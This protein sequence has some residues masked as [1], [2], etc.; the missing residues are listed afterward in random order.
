MKRIVQAIRDHIPR[1]RRRFWRYV[2][3]RRRGLG[4]IVLALLVTLVYGYW[5]LTNNERVRH[6][7]ESYLRRVTGVHVTVHDAKFR[8]FGGIVLKGVRLYVPG[9]SPDQPFLVAPRIVLRHNPAALLGGQLR[10]TDI[11]F[12]GPQV[13][14]EHDTASGVTN[15]QR[16]LDLI[17]RQQAS[18]SQQAV[19]AHLPS[20]RVRNGR[21][22]IIRRDG[23]LRHFVREAPLNLSARLEE[24][25]VYTMT[26]ES[27]LSG[28][29]GIEQ[30]RLR[31]NLAT[32]DVTGMGTVPDV[33][34]LRGVLPD[35]YRKWL[36]RYQ[37][38]GGAQVIVRSGSS[39]DQK[40]FFVELRDFS[41]RL[42]DSEG[43]LKLSNVNGLLRF[44][45]SG[46]TLV[47]R[48]VK[49]KGRIIMEG[50]TGRIPQAR[51]AKIEMWGSYDG[52]ESHS[53]FEVHVRIKDME[54]PSPGAATGELA[55]AL[56][57]FRRLYQPTGPMD[58]EVDFQRNAE[59]V[60]SYEGL[61]QAKGMSVYPKEFPYRFGNV[62]GK[63]R[64][65]KGSVETDG[66]EA[67][68]G[69]ARFVL[70]GRL[71]Y[72]LT[73]AYDVTIVSR[74]ALLDAELRNA[75]PDNFQMIWDKLSLRGST[76]ATVRLF[77]LKDDGKEDA[78]VTIEA[79]GKASMS[80]E[81]FPYRINNLF[82]EV[83]IV[84]NEVRIDSM[85]GRRGKMTCRIEGTLRDVDKPNAS[86]DLDIRAKNFALDKYLTS[87]LPR[88]TRAAVES[89]HPSGLA[90]E[91]RVKVTQKP[92]GK[93]THRI[94]AT[95][96]SGR[97][98]FE[99]FPYEVTDLSGELTILPQRVI[100]KDLRGVHRK[101]PVL[102]NGSVYLR[103]DLLGVDLSV[104]AKN[105]LLDRELFDALPRDVRSVWRTFSPSGLADV[106]LAI[107]HDAGQAG[108]KFDYG[109][110][111]DARGVDVTYRE[112]PYTFRS[113]TGR[114]IVKPG[115]IVLENLLAKQ[116]RMSTAISGEVTL[117]EFRDE[118]RLSIRASNIPIDKELLGALPPTLG[119]LTKRLRPGGE[120]DIN[121]RDLRVVHTRAAATSRP[122]TTGPVTAVTWSVRASGKQGDAGEAKPGQKQKP[123]G[124]IVLRDAVVDFG[125]GPRRVSGKLYGVA[126]GIDGAV[127]LDA[128]LSLEEVF[129]G[130]RRL[131]DIT[132]KV[133]KG[134]RS[135]VVQVKDLVGKVHGGKFAGYAQV[136]LSDPLR[137]GL[138]LSVANISL[139]ELF[140]AGITD[141][142][143]KLKVQGFLDGNIQL[144]ASV[145]DKPTRQ[146]SGVLRITKAKLYKM[147]VLLGLIQVIYLALPG[148]SA[149]T[150]GLMTY[151]LREGKLIFD[152][153]YLVGPGMSVVGSGTMD[154][155]TEK[156]K[157]S[158]LSGPPGKLPRIASIEELLGG[159][160][161]EIVEIQVTGTLSKPR[162]RAVPLRTLED[163]VRRLLNPSRDD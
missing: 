150:D 144:L 52:Y 82:G 11:L 142:G 67:S 3:P 102:I 126:S 94:D 155:A 70:K 48:R 72:Y 135:N 75:L 15:A 91:V 53:P 120:C 104:L 20:I 27:S 55:E 58:L 100:I 87:A 32:G 139:Y 42:P 49:R 130:D 108:G 84:G 31:M 113:L 156:L 64:F 121:F 59:G 12:I 129:V 132:C 9:D 85:H 95:L 28:K 89:L 78:E 133:V 56:K 38:S 16:L 60:L 5:Y 92:G 63:I 80:Y 10:P 62:R 41:M 8:L 101:T 131:S 99:S 54:F 22:R 145:G 76:G 37:L 50:V 105:V 65:S 4:V 44:D 124:L 83:R 157:V 57:N 107:R 74:D 79:D 123:P 117:G 88:A 93:V 19:P 17:R 18:S 106:D 71:P 125:F 6:Q 114:V 33:S 61:A 68:R 162:M 29:G 152:E 81:V 26:F 119:P 46:A 90:S 40:Y 86:V 77:R 116:G 148:D 69:K 7:A 147:P 149:F 122:A 127:Q 13:T 110:T 98:R 73:S 2:S 36:D 141:P 143:K 47:R 146:A 34:G 96:K 138:R 159:I 112:F 39:S 128:A 51:G 21:L 151:R 1:R 136:D 137:Y 66:L 118:A 115:K 14:L 35:E 154:T 24:R 140:N 45:R 158:F 153:I 43:G 161:R 30:G 160:L 111:I 163:A 103:D 134:P 25:N 109:L 97:F 23:Q